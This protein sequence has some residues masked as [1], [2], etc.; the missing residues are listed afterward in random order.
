MHQAYIFIDESFLT[1]EKLAQY[2]VL[3]LPAAPVLTDAEI[4]VVKQFAG[5]GG[6]LLI[7]SITGTLDEFWNG[8]PWPFSGWFGT[9][10][11][12]LGMGRDLIFKGKK[13][14]LQRPFY[15]HHPAGK[16]RS[17][18]ETLVSYANAPVPLAVRRTVGKGEVCWLNG[19]LFRALYQEEWFHPGDK[20]DFAVDPNLNALVQTLL[21][22]LIGDAASFK[23]SAPEKVYTSFYREKDMILIHFLN[24]TGFRLKVGDRMP[25]NVAPDAFPRLEKAVSAEVGTRRKIREVYAVSMDFKGRKPLPFTQEKNTVQFILPPELLKVYTIVK[26]H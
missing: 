22:G 12:R 24:H 1:P 2:K 4:K 17:G 16:L 11:S 18:S 8:R 5:N 19:E 21:N 13:I 25:W 7:T 14:R 3:M 20:Y 15:F 26:L 9:R 6:K 23:I 10:P